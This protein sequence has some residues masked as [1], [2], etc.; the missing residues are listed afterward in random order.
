MKIRRITPIAL[1]L[2]MRRP[3]ALATGVVSTAE[4]VIVRLET[5]DGIV[6]WGEAASAPTMTGE[7]LASMVRAIEELA[8]RLT[9]TEDAHAAMRAMPGNHGAKAAID[10]A[11]YD[12]MGKA[13]AKPVHELLGGAKRDS[14]A[15]LWTLAA[16]D[17]APARE[18]R[19][20]GYR[21]F[22]IKVGIESPEADAE[23]TI[24]LCR[25]LQ[26]VELICADANQGWT[27]EE[28]IRYARAIEGCGVAFL[29]Q[30][31][32]AGDID[33]MA[34]VA[35][36]S[37][38]AIAFDEG[39]HDL[40]DIR[41]HHEAHAAAG[42]SLKAIKLGGLRGLLAGAELCRSLDMRVNLAC[43]IAESGIAAA[44]LLHAAVAVPAVEWAVSLT[45]HHLVEDT[46]AAPLP[47]ASGRAAASRGAG[48]GIE[49]RERDLERYRLK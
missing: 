28:A 3:V 44:A 37:R 24:A 16:D 38:M 14:V 31:V 10:I 35:A 18:K 49:V 27:A 36:V 13:S 47:I 32:A 4:N 12:A 8:P 29:E 46:I 30:P 19:A 42:G 26:G 41:R 25:E 6:G 22:K 20:D 11:L 15:L 43:K 17:I 9:D 33:G 23:R 5:A 2:P 45:S 40:A 1:R 21:A 48:L 34:R 39:I 7:T